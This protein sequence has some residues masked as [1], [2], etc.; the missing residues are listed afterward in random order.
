MLYSERRQ[1]VDFVCS[2]QTS[3]SRRNAVCELHRGD[4]NTGL[5]VMTAVR[6]REH[7]AE[8]H[9]VDRSL[10]LNSID[11]VTVK[12]LVLDDERRTT[13]FA[14]RDVENFRVESENVFGKIALIELF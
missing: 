7:I 8:T 11:I 9:R 1:P 14:A 5:Q 12:M 4:N 6:G 2:L 10:D 3:L 13:S